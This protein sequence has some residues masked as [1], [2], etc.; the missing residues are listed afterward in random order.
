MN[1]EPASTPRINLENAFDIQSADEERLKWRLGGE[2]P[3]E[4]ALGVDEAKAREV[5]EQVDVLRAEKE[6]AQSRLNERLGNV[7]TR[8]ARFD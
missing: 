1:I 4:R 7:A 6:V 2:L 8:A 5:A 3:T